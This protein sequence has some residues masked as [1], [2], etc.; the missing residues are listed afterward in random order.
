MQEP[1][2]HCNQSLISVLAGSTR[3]FLPILKVKKEDG[4]TEPVSMSLPESPLIWPFCDDEM[5]II[6]SYAPERFFLIS[7]TY[8]REDFGKPIKALK[9]IFTKVWLKIGLGLQ[10]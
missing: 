8:T 6:V 3:Q 10:S 4:C 9:F 5:Q 1:N 7:G 2:E